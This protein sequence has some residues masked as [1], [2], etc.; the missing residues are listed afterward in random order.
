MTNKKMDIT[1]NAG[2]DA[3]KLECSHVAGCWWE[4]KMS[5]S[6]CKTIWQFLRKL[7]LPC[8]P[9]IAFLGIYPRDEKTYYHT[10]KC[11]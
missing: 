2:E 10:N 9:A 4:F 1:P 11:T 6:L 8:K 7:K 5:Q 3:E